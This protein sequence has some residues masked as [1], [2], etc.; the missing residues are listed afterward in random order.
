[1]LTRMK[2]TIELPNDL[3]MEAKAVALR[4][5]TTLKEMITHAL[6]REIA[7]SN[8]LP[9]QLQETCEVNEL[10]LWVLKKRSTSLTPEAMQDLIERQYEEEDQHILD[11]ATRP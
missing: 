9:E 2:T 5:R 7:P 3:L 4:R 10:G 11:I 8:D 1:M 6:R